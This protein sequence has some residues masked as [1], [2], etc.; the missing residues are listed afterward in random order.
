MPL[1]TR[2]CDAIRP[3]FFIGHICTPWVPV[4]RS[5]RR[6][7]WRLQRRPPEPLELG[8]PPKA[9]VG[10]IGCATWAEVAHQ[11]RTRGRAIERAICAGAGAKDCRFS[12][13][14][15]WLWPVSICAGRADRGAGSQLASDGCR[16]AP[17]IRRWWAPP[18]LS[19]PEL[20]PDQD[21]A[22]SAGAA[23]RCP[24]DRRSNA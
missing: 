20:P 9:A 7:R 13:W 23:A 17:L 4:H 5:R 1:G 21:A 8:W 19:S 22:T 24:H 12:R 6:D 15:R 3:D 2:F 14:R 10:I 18:C 16:Y 11:R